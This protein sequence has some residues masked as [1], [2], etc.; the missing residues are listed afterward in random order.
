MN[1]KSKVA[2]EKLNYKL[3][4]CGWHDPLKEFTESESFYQIVEFLFQ[5]SVAG[6]EFT[7]TLKDIFR[8]FEECPYDKLKVVV[9]GQDPYPQKGVADGIAF[10]CSRK[11]KPEKSLQY[12]FRSLEETC[13]IVN[14]SVSLKRWSNQGVLMLN[15]ALTTQVQ[16]IGAHKLIWEDF[17]KYVLT[18]ISQRKIGI[19][20]VFMG[21]VAK[22]FANK[23][24]DKHLKIL[25]THPASAAYK[26]GKW[27][28]NNCW[29]KINENL[30]A[31]NKSSITW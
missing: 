17:T 15:T 24:S 2:Q 18:I 11:M 26:G 1:S 28:C 13:D 31:Q 12:I 3:K 20:T 22:Q 14:G 7:P 10:S 6:R 19:P 23:V 9:V 30:E 16:N 4:Q 21:N 25:T 29:N 8:A 27:D 5:E